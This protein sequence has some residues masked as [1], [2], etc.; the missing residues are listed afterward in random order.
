MM[1]RD[2]MVSSRGGGGGGVRERGLETG[3]S[4]RPVKTETVHQYCQTWDI[5]T[6]KHG[7]SVLSN[8]GHQY[9]QTWVL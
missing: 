6:L 9:C 1:V 8:M 2:G 3:A 7:T 4:V 5:S